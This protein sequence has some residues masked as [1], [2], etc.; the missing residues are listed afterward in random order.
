MAI[1]KSA[2]DFVDLDSSC[3][4]EQALLIVTESA[5][6]E[7]RGLSIPFGDAAVLHVDQNGVVDIPGRHDTIVLELDHY[8]AALIDTVVRALR[9]GGRVIA[10]L[11]SES[12]PV[13]AELLSPRVLTWAGMTMIG[14]RFCAVLAAAPASAGA[15]AVATQLRTAWTAYELGSQR[16]DRLAQSE[17]LTTQIE[18]RR[19]SEQALL[20]HI[21]NLTRDLAQERARTQGL[22]L[23]QTVLQRNRPGRALLSALRPVRN[24][25]R[26]GKSLA[27][28]MR[29]SIKRG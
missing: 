24:A 17:A 5:G 7:R 11:S 26:N 28:R 9:P 4:P 21:D 14:D 22:R 6:Q 29:R 3:S 20:R 1:Q 25:T 18:Q 27:G 13:L 15:P 12:A 10:T 19:L 2:S 16:T 8:R 23:V